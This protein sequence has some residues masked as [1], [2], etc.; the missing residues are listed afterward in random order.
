LK[1][2]AGVNIGSTDPVRPVADAT[3]IDVERLLDPLPPDNRNKRFDPALA[4][5]DHGYFQR[6]HG[7][8]LS[9]LSRL[10]FARQAVQEERAIQGRRELIAAKTEKREEKERAA[11]QKKVEEDRA[12]LEAR[13]KAWEATER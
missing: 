6:N 11:R 3:G 2:S 10:Q 13:N 7:L 5:S 4:E 12:A 9:Y 1:L 8:V